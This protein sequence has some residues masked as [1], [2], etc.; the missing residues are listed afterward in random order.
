MKVMFRILCGV[1]TLGFPYVALANTERPDHQ[2]VPNPD[3]RPMSF[4]QCLE[5]LRNYQDDMGPPRIIL[6]APGLR[7]VQFTTQDEKDQ[8]ACDGD[9]NVMTV[10]DLDRD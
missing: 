9:D 6:N 1:V 10:M 3:I 2:G 5:I 4:D 7:I 8:I